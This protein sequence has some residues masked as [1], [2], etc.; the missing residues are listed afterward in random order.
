MKSKDLEKMAK[1]AGLLLIRSKGS[2]RHYGLPNM[3]IITIPVKNSKD[4]NPNTYKGIVKQ[5][6]NYR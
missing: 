1:K 2:H 4:M 5:L 3:P 6:E